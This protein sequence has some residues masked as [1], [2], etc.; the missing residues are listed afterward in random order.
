MITQLAQSLYGLWEAGGLELATQG[1]NGIR[2][3]LRL[4]LE[5]S[6][7][8]AARHEVIC[9]HA[10]NV[11]HEDDE[12]FEYA[13]PSV[14][15]SADAERITGIT[16]EQLSRCRTSDAVMADFRAFIDGAELVTHNL[17]FDLSFL[18]RSMH[19]C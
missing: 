8:D 4:D 10:V 17:E 6:G 7:L 15:L 19:G 11:W 18:S 16:N 13:R 14:P 1:R 5:M 12:F 9:Y 2:R 3:Q